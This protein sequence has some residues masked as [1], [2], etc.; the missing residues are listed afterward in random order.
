MSNSIYEINKS[1]SCTK[2]FFETGLAFWNNIIKIKEKNYLIV[3]MFF[4]KFGYDRLTVKIL[5]GRKSLDTSALETLAIGL[6]V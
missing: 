4:Y 3:N 1:G 6:I 2:L 5:T